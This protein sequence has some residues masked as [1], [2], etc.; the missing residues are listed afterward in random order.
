MEG[1]NKTKQD[2]TDISIALMMQSIKLMQQDMAEIKAELK[3]VLAHYVRREEFETKMLDFQHQL[4]KRVDGIHER[5]VELDKEK[6]AKEDFEPVKS[7]LSRINWIIISGVV[8]AIL[9][10]VIQ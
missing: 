10:L 9:A 1:K 4:D 8:V 5:I 3:A 2:Q 6:L 7:A